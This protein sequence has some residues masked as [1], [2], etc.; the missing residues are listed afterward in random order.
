MDL[1]IVV[2][3]KLCEVYKNLQQSSASQSEIGGLLQRFA[4]ETERK[5]LLLKADIAN[6]KN[7]KKLQLV[8]MVEYYQDIYSDHM[9]A[10]TKNLIRVVDEINTN[11]FETLEDFLQLHHD[12]A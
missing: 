5:A 1:S 4:A 6:L 7:L 10:L 3:L 9:R 11:N 2:R 8:P 12:L